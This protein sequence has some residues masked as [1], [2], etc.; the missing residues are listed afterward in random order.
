MLV[1]ALGYA[2]KGYFN[3]DAFAQVRRTDGRTERG[4]AAH[5]RSVTARA[6]QAGRAHRPVCHEACRASCLAGGMG[7]RGA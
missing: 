4:D 2:V 5:A 1:G 6:R 3:L 7:L